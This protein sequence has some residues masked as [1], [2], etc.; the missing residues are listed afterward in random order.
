MAGL[1]VF[2]RGSMDIQIYDTTLRDGAQQEGISLS[3][4]VVAAVD[5]RILVAEPE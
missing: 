2:G 3:V 4:E 5:A 1:F